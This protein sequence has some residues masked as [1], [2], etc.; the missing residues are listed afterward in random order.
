MG[1]NKALMNIHGIPQVGWA[2]NLLSNCC[3]KVFVSVADRELPG[4]FEFIHDQYTTGGPL[5]G[6]LSAFKSYPQATWLVLPVDMP[7]LS[8]DA[9]SYLIKKRNEGSVAICFGADGKIE[10]LPI[11]VESSGYQ[12]L[13]KHFNNGEHSLNKILRSINCE[14]VRCPDKN[15]LLNVNEPNQLG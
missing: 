2:K 7:N 11:I 14:V 5:N 13:L 8:A 6:I 3:D 15:W 1:S 10:T 9:L 12:D 4:N